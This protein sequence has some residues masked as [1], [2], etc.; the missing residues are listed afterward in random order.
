MLAA[1]GNKLHQVAAPMQAG[2]RPALWAALHDGSCV[3]HSDSMLHEQQ[4]LEDKTRLLQAM[5]QEGEVSATRRSI[6]NNIYSRLLEEEKRNY[7]ANLDTHT[8]CASIKNSL[9]QMQIARRELQS[10][11]AE[12]QSILEP[13]VSSEDRHLLRNFVRG[14]VDILSMSDGWI[15]GASTCSDV[16]S[17]VSEPAQKLDQRRAQTLGPEAFIRQKSRASLPV[18]EAMS[19]R[20][21]IAVSPSA[22]VKSKSLSTAGTTR[23]S[24]VSRRLQSQT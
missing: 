23:R 15:P 21:S 17:E 18:V 20:K 1:L 13:Q 16:S 4:A 3:Y 7:K 8:D 9:T 11:R 10:L 6:T 2:D 5:N 19:K 14:S 22:L 12:V 24:L